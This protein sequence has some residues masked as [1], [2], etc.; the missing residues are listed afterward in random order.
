MKKCKHCGET[1][2]PYTTLQKYCSAQCMKAD[3][4]YKAIKKVSA[5]RQTENEIYSQLRKV[6]LAKPENKFCPVMLQLKN[7]KVETTDI[8]HKMG[9]TGKLLLDT[10]YWLAV[11]REGHS[12]IEQNV[13][14]AKENNYSLNRL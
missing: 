13:E 4:G 5:K 6:F 14:W 2:K 9:R 8:H 3:K 1:F 7:I 12:Y 11:S 10:K